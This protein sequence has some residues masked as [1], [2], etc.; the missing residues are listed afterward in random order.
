LFAISSTD[1]L[2]ANS[3]DYVDAKLIG[4][5]RKIAVEARGVRAERRIAVRMVRRNMRVDGFRVVYAGAGAG[6]GWGT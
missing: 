4:V 2:P 6:F 5:L 1:L 3:L